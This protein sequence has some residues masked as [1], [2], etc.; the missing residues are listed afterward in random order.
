MDDGKVTNYTTITLLILKETRLERGIHQ[1]HVAER[2]DKTP[3][4]W[5]KIENGKTPFTMEMFFRAC[6][7][8]STQPSVVMA[9]TERYATFMSQ[10]G[11]CVVHK[12]IDYEEDFLL[13]EA[14]EYYASAAFKARI[15]LPGWG[16]YATALNS[17]IH[18]YDG[19]INIIDVFRFSLDPEFKKQQ[20]E[21]KPLFPL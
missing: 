19:T 1:A 17:P 12:Q 20:I 2:C 13:K 10:H 21:F 4:A 7:A 6:A 3:S 18:N 14:I 5:S 9:A 11:W 8:L 16:Q 15:P